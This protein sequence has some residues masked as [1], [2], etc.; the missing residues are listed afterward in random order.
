MRA[1]PTLLFLSL[2]SLP[3]CSR[4][5]N[6]ETGATSTPGGT[7]TAAEASSASA[8]SARSTIAFDTVRR[9]AGKRSAR[10][11]DTVIIW[12]PSA[13][14]NTLITH[15]DA[16]CDKEPPPEDCAT[17]QMDSVRKP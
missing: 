4:R 2:L 8:A 10:V 7:D 13:L 14:R 12:N 16:H 11:R 3:G 17:I 5:D 15:F 1:I 6:T 9:P